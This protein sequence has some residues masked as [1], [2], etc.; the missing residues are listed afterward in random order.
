M[1]YG[2]VLEFNRYCLVGTFHEESRRACQLGVAEC[3]GS[4]GC[5]ESSETGLCAGGRVLT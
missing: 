5:T 1:D 2:A 4:S 3:G